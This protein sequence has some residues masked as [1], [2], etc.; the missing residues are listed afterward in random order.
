MTTSALMFMEQID[1]FV[2]GSL[3]NTVLMGDLRA[4]PAGKRRDTVDHGSPS[5]QAW[6]EGPAENSKHRSL[7]RDHG[8]SA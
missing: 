7:S 8:T 1:H 5:T 2:H 4:I 3:T 6:W